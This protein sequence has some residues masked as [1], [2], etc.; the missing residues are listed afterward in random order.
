[1]APDTWIVSTFVK[2][3]CVMGGIILLLAGAFGGQSFL[4]AKVASNTASV[5]ANTTEIE[6]VK[7]I[8][9]EVHERIEEQWKKTDEKLD[10]ISTAVT[11]IQTTLEV[12]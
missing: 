5:I 3:I 2:I 7:E 12:R 9:T 4:G 11:Q 10:E 1:M 8:S 6:H